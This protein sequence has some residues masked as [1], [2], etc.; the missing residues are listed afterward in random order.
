MAYQLRYTP[1]Y[2][3]VLLFL[4]PHPN[5]VLGVRMARI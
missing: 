1:I 2:Y 5:F 3:D 4:F